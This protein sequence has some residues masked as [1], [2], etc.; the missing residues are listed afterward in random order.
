VSPATAGRSLPDPLV[1]IEFASPEEAAKFQQQLNAFLDPLIPPTMPTPPSDADQPGQ[2][3]NTAGKSAPQEPV[4]S[5]YMQQ[6]GSLILITPNPVKIQDLRPAGSKL[7]A[8]GVNFRMA[9]N[10]FATESI[11]IYFDIDGINKE[12]EERQKRSE[13]AR[14]ELDAQIAETEKVLA[15]AKKAEQAEKAET[16]ENGEEAEPPL[17]EKTI[18]NV[19][20]K[21]EGNPT[22]V[23]AASPPPFYTSLSMLMGSLSSVEAKWPAALGVAIS[24]EGDSFDIRAMLVSAPGERSDPIPFLP[25]LAPGP[26]IVPEAPSILPS[27]TEMLV[28]MSLDLPQIYAALS[29]PRPMLAPS[30]P[31]K[32]IQDAGELESPLASLERQLKIKLKDDLLPLIGPEIAVLVPMSAM[33]WFQPPKTEPPATSSASPA[34]SPTLS[35]EPSRNGEIVGVVKDETATTGR[36]IAVAIALKDK[37]RMRTLLPKIIESIAFKGASS[38]AQTERR[39]DTELVTYANIVAYAFIG[40]FL[41]I[42]PDVATTRHIVD[43]YLKHETLSGDPNFKNYT[44]WHPRQLHGQLY[45]SPSLMESYRTWAQQPTAPI[46]EKTRAFLTRFSIVPQPV[47][48][49]LSNEG[50]G[51]LHEL[52]LP[53]NLVLLLVAAMSSAFNA[54]PLDITSPDPEPPEV[55]DPKLPPNPRP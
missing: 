16:G 25:V 51:P 33:D 3:S 17:P 11:F 13:E 50:F 26:A 36:S 34:P 22:V 24:L 32:Q 39:D 2:K 19:E 37:D 41:V 54:P 35:S 48:Y 4:P 23:P 29:K 38:L 7:L 10:R 12:D 40:N 15:E 49:S 21:V 31:D 20:L 27:D 18:D 55:Q 5:Y 42:S 14:K 53:K 45:I 1:A 44:R 6:A 8:E 52:H 46:D 47:T 30:R 43:S 28:T 9:R